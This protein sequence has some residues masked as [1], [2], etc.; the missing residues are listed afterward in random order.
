[1]R[2]SFSKLTNK[3]LYALASKTDEII[4]RYSI[5]QMGIKVYYDVFKAAFGKF[6]VGVQHENINASIISQADGERDEAY[7]G[8]EGNLR[9]YIYFPDQ[10]I[11]S[12]VVE[13]LGKISKF[14]ERVIHRSYKEQTTIILSIISMVEDSY[15]GLIN[16]THTYVWF[17]LLKEKQE[18]FEKTLGEYSKTQSDAEIKSA[19][20][21]RPK[22]IIA[23]RNMFTFMPLH[24]KV[25]QNK[26]LNES[27][28][29]LKVELSGFKF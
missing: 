12:K 20:S 14:G 4:C 24:H 25:T 28:N 9:N 8:F 1:M 11:K 26:N 29:Q 2:V 10:K 15:M 3:E 27:I 16:Q 23:I 5:E 18:K 21:I 7:L 19:S 17:N 13:L 6:E 22:L